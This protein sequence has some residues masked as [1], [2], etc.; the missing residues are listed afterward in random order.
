MIVLGSFD[1]VMVKLAGVLSDC[2]VIEHFVESLLGPL[3][4]AQPRMCS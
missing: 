1:C 2:K 3:K 4:A